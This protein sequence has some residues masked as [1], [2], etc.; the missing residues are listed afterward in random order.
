MDH[1][2]KSN[3]LLGSQMDHDDLGPKYFSEVCVFLE[4]CFHYKQQGRLQLIADESF[5]FAIAPPLFSSLP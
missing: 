3:S 4:P 1:I 2:Q 5:G